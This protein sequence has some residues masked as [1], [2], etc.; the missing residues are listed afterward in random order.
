MPI[1]TG[2]TVITVSPEE[3]VQ[4]LEACGYVLPMGVPKLKYDANGLHMTWVVAAETLGK[5]KDF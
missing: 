5:V 2:T 3:I 1:E 4:I